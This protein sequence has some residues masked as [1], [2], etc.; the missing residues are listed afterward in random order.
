MLRV[1]TDC[2]GLD[3]VHTALQQSDIQFTYEFASD[4]CPVVRRLLADAPNPPA[5]IYSDIR[6]PRDPPTVDLYV[7]GPPCQSYSRLALQARGL[8]DARGTVFLSV[9]DYIRSRRP[10]VFVL[11]NVANILTR[12]GGATWA[13]IWPEICDI[14][15]YVVEYRVLS[16]HQFGWPQ[17]RKRL[18]IVGRAAGSPP[19]DWPEPDDARR[20]PDLST[21][22]L[23][24]AE[25][26]RLRPSCGRALAPGY[27]RSL[28]AIELQAK[29]RSYDLR[30]HRFI[31]MLGQSPAFDNLGEPDVAPTMTSHTENAYVP[32]QR[33][34]LCA[35]ETLLLQGFPIDHPA[36]RLPARKMRLLTGNS[37]HVGLLRLLIGKVVGERRAPARRAQAPR[38]ARRRRP[39]RRSARTR[40]D[41]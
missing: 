17:R 24:R 23:S 36:S 37:I 25:A 33:R 7:A 41:F 27:A 21:V 4:I 29:S 2:S 32:H 40:L 28:K 13:V 10:G 5:R 34:F 30:R 22:L 39:E 11:E 8:Q 35:E 14:P 1:G 20:A 38:S 6:E 9:L 19:F 3:A 16:P 18:F 12:D 31:V 15:G 26:L